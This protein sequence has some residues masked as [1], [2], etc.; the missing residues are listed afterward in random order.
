MSATPTAIQSQTWAI[1]RQYSAADVEVIDDYLNKVE[2]E[3]MYEFL[4][5]RGWGYGARSH[6][7]NN[8]SRYWYKHFAG[9]WEVPT[10]G[11][12]RHTQAEQELSQY[13]LVEAMWRKVRGQSRLLRCYANGYPFGAE[14]GVH[15]DS[16]GAEHYTL[17]YHPHLNWH[18]D[19]A[20]ETLFFN[21]R[22]NDLLCAVYPKPNRLVRF[23][24]WIP[25]VA[26]GISRLCPL[27]RITLM[28][29]VA[30]AN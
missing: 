8:P 25:H 3:K 11:L 10:A 6:M 5:G 19:W 13:P 20:G 23:P 15:I 24:G 27:L 1:P 7:G 26:R 2:Q 29:K 16:M 14:G 28:F 9:F 30:S 21:E 4:Q 18:P 17:L 12:D 22:S